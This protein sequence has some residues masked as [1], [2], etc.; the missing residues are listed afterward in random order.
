M[1]LSYGLLRL[2]KG[3]GNYMLD[4]C[5]LNTLTLVVYIELQWASVTSFAPTAFNNSTW[6]EKHIC[7]DLELVCFEIYNQLLI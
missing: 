5:Y 7:F 6:S 1:D 2:Y 3:Q 4:E